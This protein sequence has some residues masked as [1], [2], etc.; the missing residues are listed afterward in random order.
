MHEGQIEKAAQ[1]W[2][3]LLIQAAF[4][5]AIGDG[6]RHGIGGEGMGAAAID[7]AGKLV[8][9]QQQRQGA[10]RHAFPLRQ[11]AARS[12]PLD[13][14]EAFADGAVEI[15]IGGEP[16]VRPGLAPERDDFLRGH[17]RHNPR[18]GPMIPYRF[19]SR[20]RVPP[21]LSSFTS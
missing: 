11:R 1:Q 19:A 12:I 16:A 8:G 14:A 18:I 5:H 9:Q 4:Q 3:E 17:A 2:L 20:S 6:A 10:V 13:A 15:G 21:K 7:V